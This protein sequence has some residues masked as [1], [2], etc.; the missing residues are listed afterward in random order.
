MRK[1]TTRAARKMAG[2]RKHFRGGRPRKPT[3]CP[4][5][6]AAC[7]SARAALGHC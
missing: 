2:A 6:G 4:K 7:P 5:C 3:P 1:L